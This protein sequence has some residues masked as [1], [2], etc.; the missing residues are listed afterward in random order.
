[1]RTTRRTLA[2]GAALAAGASSLAAQST[3]TARFLSLSPPE[4]LPVIPVLEGWVANP[5]GTVSFSFGVIN[6][7]EEAVDIPLGE[8][9]R[10]EPARHQGAQPTHFPPGRGTGVFVVTVPGAERETDVWWHLRTGNGEPLK[11]PGRYGIPAYELDFIR[12]RPQ[13]A[14]QP[15]VGI[16]EDGPR[17]AG[18]AARFGDRPGGPARAGEPVA[19]AVNALDPAERDPTDPRFKE[20]LPM[21]VTF[22]KFQGPG[23]VRFERHESTPEPENPYRESD[24][25]FAFWEP[26][27]P[28]RLEIE[29]P[30]GVARV[31]A[32]FSEPGE[33]VIA[34]K[35]DVHRAPDSSNG[36]Q[37]CWSNVYQRVAVR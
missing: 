6:R 12:P 36:D 26:P 3:D 13:G 14:L 27:G 37:C 9:N 20:P 33:Y 32:V 8:A 2:L 35:V 21:G 15:L 31:Y 25:R 24:R 11:V 17:A 7:N 34:A 29:G 10:L 19:L 1:M 22:A 30:A 28:E 16:G 18:L 5:D 23:A 4:G